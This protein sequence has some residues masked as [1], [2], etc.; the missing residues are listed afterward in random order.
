MDLS[1]P[2]FTRGAAGRVRDLAHLRA[3][4]AAYH[5]PELRW[6]GRGEH[7]CEFRRTGRVQVIVANGR[8]IGLTDVEPSAD[9]RSALLT[10][11]PKAKRH[12]RRG[13]AGTRMP[14]S[15]DELITR[16]RGA[17]AE[18][19]YGGSHLRVTMPGWNRAVI[20]PVTPSDW[21]SI[22]NTARYLCRAG[23]NVMRF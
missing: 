1:I 11:P 19:S 23:I 14:T 16:A 13:G 4:L 18:V 7:T 10:T 6:R 5:D 17:G 21:R 12:H 3:I 22:R 15:L 2:L 8:I 9:A 20:V